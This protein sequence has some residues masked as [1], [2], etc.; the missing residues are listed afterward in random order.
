METVT[1]VVVVDVIS[2]VLVVADVGEIVLVLV[3]V[4]VVAIA[5][6]EIGGVVELDVVLGRNNMV[7]LDMVIRVAGVKKGCS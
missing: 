5:A 4:E 6:R 3:G 1:G 2:E 7:D